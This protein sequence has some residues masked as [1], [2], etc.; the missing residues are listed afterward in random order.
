MRFVADIADGEWTAC[1]DRRELEEN[2]KCSNGFL[3]GFRRPLINAGA[4]PGDVAILEFDLSKRTVNITLG[5]EELAD[6]W[7][8]GD[9][10]LPPPGIGETE[11]EDRL[12]ETSPDN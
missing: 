1:F 9:I 3:W 12:G 2:I 8:N 5:G 7:E 4:E 6:M 11:A 10:D